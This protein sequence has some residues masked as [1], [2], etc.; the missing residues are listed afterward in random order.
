MIKKVLWK[1]LQ[2]KGCESQLAQFLYLHFLFFILS[3]DGGIIIG[4]WTW[5][6]MGCIIVS[7]LTGWR[8]ICTCSKSTIA[9]NS[10]PYGLWGHDSRKASFLSIRLFWLLNSGPQAVASELGPE[11][12]SICTACSS[13]WSC[14]FPS[15][16]SAGKERALLFNLEVIRPQVQSGV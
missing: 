14:G 3:L 1:Y 16:G 6:T 13:T 4:T 5:K 12:L 2:D 8:Y 15:P 9:R 7:Q 11:G 10:F